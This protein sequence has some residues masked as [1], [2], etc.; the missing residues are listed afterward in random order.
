MTNEVLQWVALAGVGILVLGLYRQYAVAM[1]V[2]DS[3]TL[4]HRLGPRPGKK[5]PARQMDRLMDGCPDLLSAKGTLIVFISETCTSCQR[6]L[7]QLEARRD[8]PNFNDGPQVLLVI[9]TPSTKFVSALSRVPTPYIVDQEGE[10][11]RDL[12][13]GVTPFTIVLDGRG[14]VKAKLMESDLDRITK[15]AA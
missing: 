1:G 11:S 8:S 6:L 9:M 14:V 2:G 12:N 10:L 15:A 3:E 5:L 4:T 7:H 13:V